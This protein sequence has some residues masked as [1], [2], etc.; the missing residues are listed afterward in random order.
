MPKIYKDA[1]VSRYNVHSLRHTAAATMLM[2]GVSISV[3]A[4]RLGHA[5]PSTS[6]DIY[7]YVLQTAE[8]SAANATSKYLKFNCTKNNG[9]RSG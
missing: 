8:A 4:Q 2:S 5:R 7:G 9:Y 3:V 6:T 1:G